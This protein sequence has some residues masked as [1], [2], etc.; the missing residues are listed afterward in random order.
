MTKCDFCEES[1]PK[2]GCSRNSQSDRREDCRRAI[3]L[4]LHT[5][6]DI[7]IRV[8]MPKVEVFKRDDNNEN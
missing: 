5:I 3:R 8:S 1:N 7:H 4:M 2:D 6:K